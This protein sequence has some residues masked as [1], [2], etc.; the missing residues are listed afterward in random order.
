M[1]VDIASVDSFYDTGGMM[2]I[3]KLIS[4]NIIVIHSIHK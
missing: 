3:L 2:L 4:N 1:D